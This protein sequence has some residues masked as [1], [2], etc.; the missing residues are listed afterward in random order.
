MKT[1]FPG[2]MLENATI[3]TPG[4]KK[5]NRLDYASLCGNIVE[6]GSRVLSGVSAKS[7]FR[8]NQ[9]LMNTANHILMSVFFIGI[10]LS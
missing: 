8:I 7:S 5:K 1:D 4:T 2:R 3:K 10:L 9:S 6:I